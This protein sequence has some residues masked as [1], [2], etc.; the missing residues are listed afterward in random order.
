MK[1]IL[2][3]EGHGHGLCLCDAQL[4]VESAASANGMRQTTSEVERDGEAE[5][6]R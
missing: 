3:M 5:L 4:A 6:S 2:F 1:A